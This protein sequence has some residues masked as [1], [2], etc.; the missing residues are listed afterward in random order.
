M[1]PSTQQ[2][3]ALHR[4]RQP[5][6]NRQDARFR[7]R[8][9]APAQ[10]IPG[11]RNAAA[12]VLLHRDHRGS[13]VFLDPPADR[14]AR[15]Q[16]LHRRHQGDQG[17]HRRQRPPQGEG[18]YGYRARG[19]CDGARR[20][21]RPDGPVLRRRRFPLA[22]GSRAAPRR[23]RHRDLDDREPAAD[24]R[25]RAAPP[26]RRVHRS[27]RIAVQARPRSVG[28][29]APARAAS[30]RAAIPAARDHDGATGR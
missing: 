5:L 16:R 27:R 24:D 20:A 23:P 19:R 17:V 12:R 15:L 28:T 9:Q 22:G 21:Y 4:W 2:N 25:R 29:S 7:H 8:L 13:G 10:G 3:R 18:Q 14:L 1:P 30:S 11:P 26:G 6:R